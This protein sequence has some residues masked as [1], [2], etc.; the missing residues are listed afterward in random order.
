MRGY[1]S[2]FCLAAATTWT[3]SSA[4]SCSPVAIAGLDGVWSELCCAD[5]VINGSSCDD[6]Y[7][8]CSDDAQCTGEL[9]CGAAGDSCSADIAT[10]AGESAA[11]ARCCGTPAV[12]EADCETVGPDYFVSELV[13]EREVCPE[14]PGSL[15]G[16]WTSCPTAC[17]ENMQTAF[18]D[19]AV[20]DTGC[21]NFRWYLNSYAGLGSDHGMYTDTAVTNILDLCEIDTADTCFATD[22]ETVDPDEE[23]VEQ[24][25]CFD[26]SRD[27]FGTS[28][29]LIRGPDADPDVCPTG[30]PGNWLECPA[31]CADGMQAAI[32]ELDCCVREYLNDFAGAGFDHGEYADMGF[33]NTM[34]ICNVELT[35]SPCFDAFNTQQSAGENSATR[36]DFVRFVSS[37]SLLS[38]LALWFL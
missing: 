20:G 28:D 24:S 26:L 23:T 14:Y 19:L 15:P 27:F 37:S 25:A 1:F 7:G 3:Q 21:C 22:G 11:T 12:V 35:D 5:L 32:D 31:A 17:A 8:G 9:V 2:V 6:G 18:N 36:L 10:V 38:A 30:L 4:Q 34:T 13:A 29:D 33:N 16:A